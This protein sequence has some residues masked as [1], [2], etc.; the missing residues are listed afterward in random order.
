MNRRKQQQSTK[1]KTCLIT[2]F[3][4]FGG[5][6]FNPS[7]LLIDLLP[8]EI[9]LRSGK[10]S[11]SGTVLPTCCSGAWTKLRRILAT[12]KP[13]VLLLTGLAQKRRN[14]SIERF[15]L[16]IRDYR[17]PDNEGH[18]WEGQPIQRTGPAALQTDVPLDRLK[19]VM[20]RSGIPT[21]ISNHA[22]SFVCNEMYYRALLHQQKHNNKMVVLFVHMPLPGWFGKTLLEHSPK[23]LSRKQQTRDGQMAVILQ[24]IVKIAHFCC[25]L[26]RT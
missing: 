2:G 8:H 22:G 9:T 24:G 4:S 11:V 16:N 13:D 19:A 10:V 25:N 1:Q 12:R 23:A 20:S 6:R 7:E 18:I 17:I 21:E 14:L 3:D 15:A 5:S 26:D